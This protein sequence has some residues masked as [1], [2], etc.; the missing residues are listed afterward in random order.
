MIKSVK[1]HIIWSLNEMSYSGDPVKLENYEFILP[2]NK[3]NSIIITYFI[4]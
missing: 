3:I 4:L 2:E 1:E